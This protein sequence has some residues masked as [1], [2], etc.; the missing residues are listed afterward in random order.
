M[1]PRGVTADYQTLLVSTPDTCELTKTTTETWRF[2][3]SLRSVAGDFHFLSN[4]MPFEI[5]MRD[6]T[7]REI[8]LIFL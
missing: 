7:D 8:Q 6:D 5:S 1:C 2:M 4:N 3:F